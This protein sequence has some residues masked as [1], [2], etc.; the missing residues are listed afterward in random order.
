MDR[1][2]DGRPKAKA[3]RLLAKDVENR[4]RGKGKGKHSDEKRHF[5]GKCDRCGKNGHMARDCPDA[6]LNPIDQYRIGSDRSP[7]RS[8]QDA[9]SPQTGVNMV[10]LRLTHDAKVD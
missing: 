8:S 7:G 4:A 10:T 2:A 5:I 1:M 3:E 9:Q 6:A